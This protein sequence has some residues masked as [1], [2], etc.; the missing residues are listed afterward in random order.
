MKK[1]Y[2]VKFW[3]QHKFGGLCFITQIF[4][5]NCYKMRFK[6]KNGEESVLHR[7]KSD[8]PSDKSD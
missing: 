2:L 7:D 8:R 3:I 1:L 6:K 5:F 4:P